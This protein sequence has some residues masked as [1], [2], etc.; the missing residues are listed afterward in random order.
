M[1][2]K[3]GRSQFDQTEKNVFWSILK[4]HQGGKIWKTITESK[5]NT[6]H[7]DAWKIVAEVFANHIGSGFSPQQAIKCYCCSLQFGQNV[8]RG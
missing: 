7:H 3:K 8:V 2:D 4:S 1:E 5:N 6:A